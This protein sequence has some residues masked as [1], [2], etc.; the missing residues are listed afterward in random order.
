MYIWTN[1]ELK[2]IK[3]F[4]FSHAL[5]LDRVRDYFLLLAWT[6]SRYSDLDKIHPQDVKDGFISF[7]Q[8]KTNDKVTIPI[9]PVVSEILESMIITCQSY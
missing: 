8:Q 9:H 1:Q 7:R 4:D 3:D 2:Q 6:G 5:H